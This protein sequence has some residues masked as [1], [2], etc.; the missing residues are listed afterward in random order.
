MRQQQEED[1]YKEM[2]DRYEQEMQEMFE[3][4]EQ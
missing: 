3:G 1:Y 2:Y 4:G